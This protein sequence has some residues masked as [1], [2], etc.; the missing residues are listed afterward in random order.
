MEKEFLTLFFFI[1]PFEKHKY[2]DG[3]PLAV[4]SSKEYILKKNYKEQNK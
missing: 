1:F 2:G 3:M 4:S